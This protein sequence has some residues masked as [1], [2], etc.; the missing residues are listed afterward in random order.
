MDDFGLAVAVVFVAIGL[1]LLL[2]ALIQWGYNAVEMYDVIGGQE[3]D[4]EQSLFVA[5]LIAVGL[6]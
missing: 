5:L 4:Y 3:I 1:V 2:A 6:K